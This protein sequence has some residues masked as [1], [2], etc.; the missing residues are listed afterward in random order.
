MDVLREAMNIQGPQVNPGIFMISAA[1]QNPEGAI[2]NGHTMPALFIYLLNILAKMCMRQ[3]IGESARNPKS[4][5]PIGVIAVSIFARD[6]FRWKTMSFIDIMIAK[7]R[8]NCPVLFGVRGSDKTEVGRNRLGW[9]RENDNWISEPEHNDRM[10]GL[11]AGFASISLR[12]FS[13]SSMTNPW[14]PINYWQAVSRIVNTPSDETSATHYLVLKAMIDGY[15]KKILTLF[16]RQGINLLKIALV[17]FPAN[18]IE[19]TAAVSS[20]AVIA[21][22][23][24]RDDSLVLRY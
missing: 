12:D 21:D 17:D 10:M 7:F 9:K 20:L 11:G 4:A 22:R 23:L 18:A 2:N 24:A 14:P 16:G 19:H 1:P 15:E 3:F 6:E 13:K 8:V 5:D